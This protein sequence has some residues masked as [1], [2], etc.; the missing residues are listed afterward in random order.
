[1][2]HQKAP[3]KCLYLYH[4]QLALL[5]VL[6]AEQLAVRGSRVDTMEELLYDTQT[7]YIFDL[8]PEYRSDVA[9]M[10]S[11]VLEANWPGQIS[12]PYYK[13]LQEIKAIQIH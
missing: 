4:P 5:T 7:H 9:V 8:R 11:D 3:T 12:E 2:K 1:M 10:L 6:G 13:A